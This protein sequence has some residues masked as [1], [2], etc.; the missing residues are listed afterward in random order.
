[1]GLGITAPSSQ[2]KT[3]WI[4][5]LDLLSLTRLCRFTG[6]FS[7]L[8]NFPIL[9]RRVPLPVTTELSLHQTRTRGKL[10]VHFHFLTELDLSPWNL[11][12]LPNTQFLK[13]IEKISYHTISNTELLLFREIGPSLLPDMFLTF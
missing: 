9:E 3:I 7:F 12:N 11:V 6:T 10:T 8:L 1:M 5:Y 2:T 13:M 4:I